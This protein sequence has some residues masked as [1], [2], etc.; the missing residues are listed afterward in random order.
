MPQTGRRSRYR[1]CEKASM[2]VPTQWYRLKADTRCAKP[3]ASSFPLKNDKVAPDAPHARHL[4]C[5]LNGGRHRMA[6]AGLGF[7]TGNG[8]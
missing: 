6:K 5:L 3:Y 8:R 4:Y 7:F 2:Q 1:W